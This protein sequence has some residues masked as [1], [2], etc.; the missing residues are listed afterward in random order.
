MGNCASCSR[1]NEDKKQSLRQ[2]D[3][4][5][6]Y[7]YN[8]KNIFCNNHN[9]SPKN[10]HNRGRNN[11]LNSMRSI[12]GTP[13]SVRAMAL[14]NHS[15]HENSYIHTD[16]ISTHLRQKVLE[17]SINNPS[18]FLDRKIVEVPNE[19]DELSD[20]KSGSTTNDEKKD[21]EKD[22]IKPLSDEETK[23]LSLTSI[24]EEDP[25]FGTMKTEEYI[26]ETADVVTP[27]LPSSHPL[28]QTNGGV[29]SLARFREGLGLK[30]A[31]ENE[32][33]W[34]QVSKY[35]FSIV[36]SYLLVIFLLLLSS[37]YLSCLSCVHPVSPFNPALLLY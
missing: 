23:H 37:L 2:C 9:N 18:L 20:E 30:L 16:E 10:A 11:D 21:Q 5:D 15:R 3:S 24:T 7:Y 19:N 32:P 26:D 25:T 4:D 8:K 1:N 28:N 34:G 31:V 22:R 35:T 6:D 12:T 36:V 29:R 27:P 33:D 13:K 14:L 17:T